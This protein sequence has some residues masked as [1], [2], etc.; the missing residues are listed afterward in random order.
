MKNDPFFKFAAAIILT[1]LLAAI[2]ASSAAPDRAAT[3]ASAE[4]A[5]S[6]P[7]TRLK[8]AVSVRPASLPPAGKPVS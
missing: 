4:T 3:A 8:N 2:A 7:A 1:G 6:M 5:A